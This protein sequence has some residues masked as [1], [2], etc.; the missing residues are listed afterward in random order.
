MG[1]D[2]GWASYPG[3]HDA[4]EVLAEFWEEYAADELG[5]DEDYPGREAVVEAFGEP[6]TYDETIAPYG[7]SGR[8]SPPPPRRT[9]TRT[10]APPRSPTPSRTAAR[11]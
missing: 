7:P 9:P 8:A 6:T 3:D 11:G 1:V 10:R 5:A 2:A 4:E